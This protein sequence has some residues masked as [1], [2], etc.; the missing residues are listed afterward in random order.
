MLDFRRD[1]LI[2]SNECRD[3]ANVSVGWEVE[4]IISTEESVSS[5]LKVTVQRL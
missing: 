5:M 3:M 1:V 4:G 2:L